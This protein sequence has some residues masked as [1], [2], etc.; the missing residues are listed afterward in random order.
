[1]TFQN[2][3]NIPFP[4]TVANGGTGVT[5]LTAYAVLA[6]GATA[7]DPI[8]SI[9]PGVAGE[10]LMSNGAGVLPSFQTAPASVTL[11]QT[12][13][14][15]GASEATFTGLSGR[16]I[17]ELVNISVSGGVGTAN[18]FAQ[19]SDDNGATWKSSNYLSGATLTSYNSLFTGGVSSSDTSNLFLVFP[20]TGNNAVVVS[21]TWE[22]YG[23][24][25]AT[26]FVACWGSGWGTP[27]VAGPFALYLLG[28]GQYTVSPGTITPNALRIYPAV[29][30]FSGTI[31][32]YQ[33]AS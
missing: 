5:S 23:F 27:A 29:G 17:I 26:N 15:S 4:A 20:N 19:I 30:T 32:L 18:I 33:I 12:A 6:A 16:Y 14:L 8:Q 28:G 21:G 2:S 11:A 22:I 24:G 7:T 3:I 9:G 31:N 1:M 25:A 13:T 10:A